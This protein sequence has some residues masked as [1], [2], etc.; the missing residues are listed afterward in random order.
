LR[1]DDQQHCGPLHQQDAYG[2]LENSGD[3][4]SIPSG[5]PAPAALFQRVSAIASRGVWPHLQTSAE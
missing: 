5:A 4:K 3:I 1:R 2:K